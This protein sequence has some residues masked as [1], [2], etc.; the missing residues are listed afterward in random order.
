MRKFITGVLFAFT[1]GVA[2]QSM[3]VNSDVNCDNVRI[4]LAAGIDDH[5][6]ANAIWKTKGV[7]PSPSQTIEV[8]DRYENNNDPKFKINC[9]GLT[10]KYDGEV[11]EMKAPTY[12]D[13]I[14]AFSDDPRFNNKIELF[15]YSWYRYPAIYKGRVS[16]QYKFDL[17]T[18]RLQTGYNQAK[19]GVAVNSFD[20]P[21]NP[22]IGYKVDGSELRPLLFDHKVSNYSADF[23]NANIID[24]YHKN[25]KAGIEGEDIQRIYVDK[26]NGLLKIYRNFKF[27]TK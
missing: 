21:N 19:E 26:A 6:K 16:Q 18:L 11:L 20:F 8:G 4:N 10:V 9:P 1:L 27:P 15:Q 24:I 22:V 14:K 25:P 17:S 12:Q 2:S 3:A 13:V 5:F 23:D 7:F